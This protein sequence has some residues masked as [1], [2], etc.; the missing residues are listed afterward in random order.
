MIH[1][2][3]ARPWR[4]T[5]DSPSADTPFA[6]RSPRTAHFGAASSYGCGILSGL[7]GTEDRCYLAAVPWPGRRLRFESP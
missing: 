7:A 6:F 3:R 2:R 4:V 1:H 5:V